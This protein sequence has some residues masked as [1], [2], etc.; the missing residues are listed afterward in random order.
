MTY[1]DIVPEDIRG[2][3]DKQCVD[4]DQSLHTTLKVLA[5]DIR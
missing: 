4:K 2:G 1:F 5:S 3:T